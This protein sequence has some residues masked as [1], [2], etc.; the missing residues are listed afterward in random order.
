V[1]IFFVKGPAAD[2]TDAPQPWG[3]LCNPVMKMISFFSFFRVMEHRWNETDRGKPKYSGGKPCPNATLYTTNPTRTDPGSNPSL[4]GERPATNRLSHGTAL[5]SVRDFLSNVWAETSD[6]NY[7][8]LG[9][10]AFSNIR[11][12]KKSI[13]QISPE[14]S[15][16]C[17]ASALNAIN[18]LLCARACHTFSFNVYTSWDLWIPKKWVHWRNFPNLF[19]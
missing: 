6:S 2:A 4:R 5:D 18:S 15:V 11:S 13:G 9:H 19:A 3:L 14:G 10:N 17:S 16:Q 8:S 1:D 12:L 7:P